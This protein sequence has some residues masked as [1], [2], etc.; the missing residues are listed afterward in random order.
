MKALITGITGQDGAYLSKLLIEKGYEVHGIQRRASS[1]N[2]GRLNEVLSDLG[3]IKDLNLTLHYGDLTDTANISDLVSS[4]QPNEIYNLAAQSHVQVSFDTPEYTANADAVGTLRLLEAIRQAKPK[5]IRFYQASTSEMFGKVQETPQRE[6]TPFYPRSPYGVAKLY[7]HWITVNYRE[8]YDLH[9]SSGIL[10]N[11]ESPFRGAE[12]VTR[13]ITRAVAA[14]A[15]GHGGTL[16]L[17]NL[18]ARRDWGHARDYVDGMWRM[19]Q[20]ETPDDYVLATGETRSVREFVEVAFGH[21]G[22]KID[23]SGTGTEETGRDAQ[24]GDLLVTVDPR[25]FRPAEVDLLLGDPAKAKSGL[26]WS[27]QTSFE[28]LVSEMMQYDI[29]RTSAAG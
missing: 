8:A 29:K 26:G 2:T 27:P 12:F 19:L 10:F 5:Q 9:A 28:D 7:A 1:D 4:I 18:D 6:T 20:Q 22:Q 23:W 14:K 21:I 17:G 15:A 11:H 24:T 16:S 3:T 13:K 25:F